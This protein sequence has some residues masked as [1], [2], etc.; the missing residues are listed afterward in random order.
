MKVAKIKISYTNKNPIKIKIDS[1]NDVYNLILNHWNDNT[2]ELMEEVKIIL[3][4]N[5]N[6]VLGVHELSK[7][8]ISKCTIDL[9]IILSIALKCFN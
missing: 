5:D 4:N 7:G 1:S 2:I 3:L 9:K 8:G 6:V